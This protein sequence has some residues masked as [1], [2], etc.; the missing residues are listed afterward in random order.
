MTMCFSAA[1]GGGH[2]RPGGP[3]GVGTSAKGF[4]LLEVMVAMLLFFLAVFAILDAVNQS[5]R[6][7]RS[8]Q[9]NLPDAGVL[10]AEF[11]LTNR[12]EEGESSGDFGELYPDFTWSRR[13]YERETNGLYQ[14]DFVISGL[15]AGRV[16]VSTNSLLLWRPGSSQAL[17]GLRRPP[18][19][20]R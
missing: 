11:Y 13:I 12:V 9:V 10:A 14:V 17:P 1:V 4:T 19:R 7:A 5:V 16:Q 15:V 20:T 3:A 18:S 2:V 6:A 8:L